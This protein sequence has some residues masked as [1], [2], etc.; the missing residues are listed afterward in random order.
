[1]YIAV[2]SEFPGAVFD[3]ASGLWHGN[4]PVDN[5]ECKAEWEVVPGEYIKCI[6]V[7]RDKATGEVVKNDVHVMALRPLI[8]A[9]KHGT[10]GG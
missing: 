5:Y 9:G 1:M 7:W 3:A 6:P 10:F 2:A 8:A 4:A